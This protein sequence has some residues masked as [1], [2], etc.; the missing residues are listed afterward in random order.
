[1]ARAAPR[2]DGLEDADGT[3]PER[4]CAVTRA[5]RQP[6]DL[7]RFVRSPDGIIVPDLATRLPGR[8]VWV[9]L[10]R[11]AVEAAARQNVFARSLKRQV[12]VPEDL[13]GQVERLLRRR[14][15][16]ALAIANKAGLV[17]AGF[18]KVEAALD[19][20]I[21][22]ALVHASDAAED[23]QG[24]LDRK[25][26]A[27]A[28]SNRPVPPEPPVAT[29]VASA[30]AGESTAP[31]SQSSAPVIVAELTSEELSLALGR[32]NVVHAALSNGGAARHFLIEAGRF[33]RYRLNS[34]R[35]AGRPPRMRPNTEQV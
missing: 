22:L 26:A 24:K 27:I 17:V 1:M 6:E 9:S 5:H 20:G 4:T 2:D 29:E 12:S 31:T 28:A 3:G 16:E 19:K 14:C 25:F 33:R 32:E 23:G 13:A 8:G 7:I 11:G 21:V 34:H 18:A 10:D 30:I 15:Q 35:I